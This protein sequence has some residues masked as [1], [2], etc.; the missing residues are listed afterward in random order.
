TTS[1]RKASLFYNVNRRRVQEW[2]KQK[3][4][5]EAVKNNKKLNINKARVLSGRG[6]KAKY[7]D[8]EKDLVDYIKK[9]R[10]EKLA[11]TTHMIQNKAK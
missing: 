5:L 3:S 7:P 8:L 10:D 4:E 11:V 2:R 1:N 9:K 6:R